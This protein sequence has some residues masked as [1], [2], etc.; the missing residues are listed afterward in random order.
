MSTLYLPAWSIGPDC[1]K[2]IYNIVRPYGRKAALIGGKISMEK[3]LP[4]LKAA[5]DDTDLELSEP[6]WFGGEAS[7]ENA[8]KLEAMPE[9]KDADMIFAVGGGRSVDTCKCAAG[10][11][12][13]PVF[14]FPTL[15]SNCASCTLLCVMYYPD[16]AMRDL[17]YPKRCPIHTFMDTTIIASSPSAYLW[18]G[19]GDSL[20]KEFESEMA[21]RNDLASF[22]IQH[23]PLMGAALAR[24]CTPAFLK[25]GEKAMEQI[26][27]HED[28][29]E[30]QQVTLAI[31]ITAG[32]V[33]NLT[34]ETHGAYF[35]NDSLAHCFYYG[36]T[37][38][39]GAHKHLHGEVVSL[40][41][42]VLLTLDGQIERRNSLFPF[43]KAIGLPMTLD[44][45]ELTEADMPTLLDKCV[46]QKN[47]YYVPSPVTREQ[48]EQAIWDTDMAA[49]EWLAANK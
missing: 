3:A 27:N 9:V 41:I 19:I 47:W 46:A 16:G 35:Y 32:L 21:A 37:V 44:A 17:F 39:P 30:L 49:K 10:H 29:Y 38:C 4:H 7:Y 26:Q 13:K 42:L 40:G 12:D 33:S 22:Q 2:E 24:C 48:F 34:V 14:T 25:F 23:A 18:A 43:Y 28:G 6:I 45:I 36:T 11:L 1:Y 20:A 31:V 15:A 5:L 8:A